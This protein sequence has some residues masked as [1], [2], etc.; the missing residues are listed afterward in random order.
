MIYSLKINHFKKCV[1]ENLEK[2]PDKSLILVVQLFNVCTLYMLTILLKIVQIKNSPDSHYGFSP[3]F[4]ICYF[5]CT[6]LE[7][8]L[9]PL[10]WLYQPHTR[11][12]PLNND[13]MRIIILYLLFSTRNN[14]VFVVIL[15][16]PSMHP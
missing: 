13:E 3:S 7:N 8:C 5:I 15:K 14:S 12:I 10:C 9:Q 6:K 2:K 4:M 11:P 1:Y 16:T